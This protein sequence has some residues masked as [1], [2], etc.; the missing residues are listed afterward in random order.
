MASAFLGP[1]T[2]SPLSVIA[3]RYQTKLNIAS[4]ENE[5]KFSFGV[6]YEK[7]LYSLIDDHLELETSDR[8]V[9]LLLNVYL[10]C[11]HIVSVSCFM[12]FIY[13]FILGNG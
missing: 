7:K 11:S 5:Q 8:L 9:G 13:L 1:E 6:E 12:V 4:L 3:E 10:I 2:H